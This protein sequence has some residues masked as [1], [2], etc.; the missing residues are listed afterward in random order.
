MSIL[1]FGW[2][3]SLVLSSYVLVSHGFQHAAFTNRKLPVL[4]AVD[5]RL[6][7]ETWLED[8]SPSRRNLLLTSAVIGSTAFAS[9]ASKSPSVNNIPTPA[10]SVLTLEQATEIIGLRCNKKFLHN[11]IASDYRFLY[12]GVPDL[13]SPTIRFDPPDLLLPSAYDSRDAANYFQ[14]LDERMKTELV[15]PSNSHLGTTN[16][17]E[18]AR[19]GTPSSV[20]P[21]GDCH[22]AW[23]ADGGNFLGSTG[24]I[25][26]DGLNCGEVSLDDALRNP[27]TEIMFSG[28]EGFLTVPIGLD[29]SLRKALQES[30]FI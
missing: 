16:P 22:F 2:I 4:H 18:A 14:R 17:S 9:K 11:V 13:Q 5:D 1:T 27:R 21:L 28:T 25:L 8:V 29:K 12:F 19:W 20:W 10:A 6:S 23:L 24:N 3:H 7:P 30:F 15:R 26:V